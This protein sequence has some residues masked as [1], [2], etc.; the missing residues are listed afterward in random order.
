[1]QKLWKHPE[2]E[3]A[4]IACYQSETHDKKLLKKTAKNIIGQSHVI[5]VKLITTKH[6]RNHPRK[7]LNIMCGPTF[8]LVKYNP[9]SESPLNKKLGTESP[10]DIQGD[11]CFKV[12]HRGALGKS[13]LSAYVGAWRSFKRSESLRLKR[14]LKVSNLNAMCG[15]RR[16]SEWGRKARGRT[17]NPRI[18]YS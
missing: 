1:M 2:C 15:K 8:Y 11:L 16:S 12:L 9:T 13:L 17:L 6:L 3:T 4:R 5:K 7:T 14:S 18:F 10:S